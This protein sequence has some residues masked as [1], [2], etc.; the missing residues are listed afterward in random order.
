MN[1]MLIPNLDDA[2]ISYESNGGSLSTPSLFGIDPLSGHQEL[3]LQR[4]QWMQAHNLS[5][6]DI[7]SHVVNGSSASFTQSLQYMIDVTNHL[8]TQL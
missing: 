7:F 2:V 5:L 1:P 6:E 3:L 4:E 8:A